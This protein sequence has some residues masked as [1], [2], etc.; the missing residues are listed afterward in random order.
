MRL[1]HLVGHGDL[2]GNDSIDEWCGLQL[3]INDEQRIGN[4]KLDD[5]GEPKGEGKARVGS[6]DLV[7]NRTAR[8]AVSARRK[9]FPR[10]NKVRIKLLA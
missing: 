2:F 7:W 9:K 6:V 8:A 10:G 1:V 3:Y 5:D 4:G